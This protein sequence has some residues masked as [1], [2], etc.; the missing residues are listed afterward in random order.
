M[1]LSPTESLFTFPDF[2]PASSQAHF[3]KPMERIVVSAA[4]D[5][6][7]RAAYPTIPANVRVFGPWTGSLDNA[8]ERVTLQDKNNV[9]VC[10]VNYGDRGH[11][12]RA[13]DG[14]GHSLVLADENRPIDDWR[15]W[16][17]STNNVGSAGIADP[18]PPAQPLKLNEAHFTAASHIDWIEL[19]NDSSANASATGLFLTSKADLSGKVAVVR[20]ARGGRARELRR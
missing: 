18:A 19:R 7:T 12:P 14:P 17:A 4:S 2:N 9:I 3:L 1:A 13:A 20:A 8:G 11:W 15:V 5:A 10:T 16:R 6:A